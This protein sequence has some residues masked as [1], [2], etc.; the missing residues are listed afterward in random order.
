M[1]PS[2]FDRQRSRGAWFLPDKHADQGAPIQLPYFLRHHP[3]F[4][5]I[6]AG[7]ANST[8]S[9]GKVADTIYIWSVLEPLFVT[10]LL[11]FELRSRQ[12]RT[13]SREDYSVAWARAEGLLAALGLDIAH[14]F[15]AMRYGSGWHRLQSGTKQAIK[16][17]VLDALV[18]Q[19]NFGNR[20]ALPCLS[21]DTASGT[22]LPQGRCCRARVSQAGDHGRTDAH[23]H[24][25]FRWRLARPSRSYI[26]EEADASEKVITTLPETRFFVG[27]KQRVAEVAAQLGAAG[28]GSRGDGRGLWRQERA[29]SPIEERITMLER[30]WRLF[31]EIHARQRTGMTNLW[32]L[33]EDVRTVRLDDTPWAPFNPELYRRLLPPT[34]WPIL[35]ACGAAPC[36]RSGRSA[37]SAPIATFPIR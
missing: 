14:D 20:S 5:T 28:H 23:A 15:A 19:V 31:D 17:R 7:H 26:G 1:R 32:G 6:L 24:R 22:I 2:R 10:L 4:S 36:S 21:T 8:M 3:R 30:Y 35:R 27:G 37:S 29:E 13:L 16:E 12:S 33:V 25:L 9:L 34:C 11:P 18:R